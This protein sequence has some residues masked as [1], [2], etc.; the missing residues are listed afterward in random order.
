MDNQEEL[1]GDVGPLPVTRDTEVMQER[2]VRETKAR[3]EALDRLE[4]ARRN[5]IAAGKRIARRLAS[6]NGRVTSTE[7][8]ATM[9]ADAEYADDLRKFDPRWAGC[10]FLGDE[11]VPI[12]YEA[13]GS[14][15]RPVRIW[16]LSG[17]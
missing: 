5:I 11:W 16:A 14:H 3:D 8:L 1:F 12:G 15:R 17:E 13:E 4:E 6:D 2:R 10:L 9:R 7:V